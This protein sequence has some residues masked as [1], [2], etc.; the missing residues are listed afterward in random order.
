MK[1]LQF[2]GHN[3]V[4]FQDAPKPIADERAIVLKVK[5]S[6]ICGSE[7]GPFRGE[8]PQREG[9]HNPG[10]EVVGVIEE[11]PPHSAY[12]PGMRVG[13]RVVQGCGQCEFCK[14][15]YETACR[16]RVL[17]AGNAHAQF[18][19]LGINGVQPIPDGVD[20]P[21]ATLLTG[22]GLG[23][24]VRCAR[25][26]GDTRDAQVL[27]LGLGPVGLSCLLVQAH[28]GARVMGADLRAY[29]VNLARE[30]GAAKA[31]NIEVQD[32]ERE[33]MDW[34]GGKGADIVILAVGKN[35]ALLRAIDLVRQQG[36]VFQVGELEEAT[37][38]PSAA[39]IRKEITMTGSWY[40][41]SGDWSEMLAL[42]R[43]GLPYPKLITHVYPFAQAQTAYDTFV[44]GNSGKVVLTYD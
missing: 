39:F 5:A 22:D 35:E 20:W 43:A 3:K 4:G 41:T 30:L 42:H 18:F 8:P 36:R 23:V 9:W 31:V 17:Y 10:H 11:A 6:A 29:R 37:L 33:V 14:I 25:R 12:Q 27:V 15:G 26:L 28:R 24:S 2:L 32:L 21:A 7:L 19:R 40:Y 13:A 38:N 34:T 16:D 44:S 1:I